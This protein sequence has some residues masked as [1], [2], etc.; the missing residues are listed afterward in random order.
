M[1]VAVP[2]LCKALVAIL[3][4][5]RPET[6]MHADVVHHVA[7]FGEGIAAGGADKELVGATGVLILFEK[8]HVTPLS[9]VSTLLLI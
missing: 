4:H 6:T 9:F 5:K 8:L 2:L 7:Q 1:T 3:A